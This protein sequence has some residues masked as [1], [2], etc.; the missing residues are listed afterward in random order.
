M[1][2][3]ASGAPVDVSHTTCLHSIEDNERKTIPGDIEVPAGWGLDVVI[4]HLQDVKASHELQRGTIQHM[5]CIIHKLRDDQQALRNSAGLLKAELLDIKDD[6]VHARVRHA[7]VATK[8]AAMNGC[9]DKMCMAVRHL[10]DR[11]RKNI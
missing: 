5:H 9:M 3:R 4:S 7:T 11:V 1:A 10:S 8:L 2:V 6:L